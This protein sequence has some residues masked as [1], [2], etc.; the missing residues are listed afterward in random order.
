MT[1]ILIYKALLVLFVGAG[2]HFSSRK[3][4]GNDKLLTEIKFLLFAL[5]AATI[6]G[7]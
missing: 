5:V 3:K 7:Q 2:V 1:S 4:E 6:G